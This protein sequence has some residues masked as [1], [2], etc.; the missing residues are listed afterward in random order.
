[1]PAW[2]TF[3]YEAEYNFDLKQLKE[4]WPELHRGDC[5][6]WPSNETLQKAWQ[7]YHAGR[8]NKAV[9]TA[10]SLGIEA[11]APH[12]KAMIIYS[13]HLE[14]DELEQQKLYQKAVDLTAIARETYPEAANA[15]YLYAF[16]LG[17]YAQSISTAKALR[18]GMG[19]KIGDS[20]DAT[21]ACTAKHADAHLAK[22]LFHAEIVD[23]VG[24]LVAKMTYGANNTKALE[25]LEIAIKLNPKAPI[26]WIEY[27]NGIYT[28]N[29]EAALG[30][31]NE[32]YSKAAKLTSR[33]AV[34]RLDQLFAINELE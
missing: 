30:D 5:E 6:P 1:M 18:Q 32:A 27:G 33:D 14:D 12:A 11:F 19:G 23:K 3:K 2:K 21:L 9:T 28:I 10:E 15:H 16:A 13:D 34:E 8:F 7:H 24:K 4:R 20:I 25:H 31:A 29:G 17:R 26:S 22:G